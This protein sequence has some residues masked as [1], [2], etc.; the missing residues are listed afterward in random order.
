MGVNVAAARAGWRPSAAPGSL[1]LGCGVG[2]G[3]GLS[4][5]FANSGSGGV[6]GVASPASFRIAPGDPE[7]AVPGFERSPIP[8]RQCGL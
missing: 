8:E 1:A 3:R 7:N 2:S 5:R 4:I 6:P